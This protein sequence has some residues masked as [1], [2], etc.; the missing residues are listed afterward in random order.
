MIR[1][2]YE[3]SICFFN[4]EFLGSKE[5]YL[6]ILEKDRGDIYC[7]DG[8]ANLL[9]ELKLFPK[10]IWGDFDSVSEEIL[11]KYRE[12]RVVIKKFPKIRI[13]LMGS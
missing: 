5:Y 1:G 8:G 3:S 7:A 6:N 2:K 12:N 10:E 4:G 9:E 13:I 11:D